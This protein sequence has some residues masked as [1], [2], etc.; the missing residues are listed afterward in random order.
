VNTAALPF[1]SETRPG[2]W[3]T[4]I[5]EFPA[6]AEEWSRSVNRL[7]R[8]EEEHLLVDEPSAE[9]L[10]WHRKRIERLM[11]FGQLC[12]LVATHPELGDTQTAEIVMATQEVLRNKLRMFHQPMAPDAAEGLLK[13]VFP[14]PGT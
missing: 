1:D 14:E 12:A 8:W 2:V 10:A 7:N 9:K 13:E 5:N 11:F 3:E 4:V 6:S